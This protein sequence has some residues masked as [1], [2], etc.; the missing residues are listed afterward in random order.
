MLM[1]W[2]VWFYFQESAEHLSSSLGYLSLL[3]YLTTFGIIG[4][5]FD[6]YVLFLTFVQ[7]VRLRREA[8]LCLGFSSMSATEVLTRALSS[9]GEK[10]LRNMRTGT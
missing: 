9:S 10:G 8:F 3:A 4:V 2:L 1:I 7:Q 6:V 5:R